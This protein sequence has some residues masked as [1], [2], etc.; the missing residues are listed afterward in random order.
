[1][2]LH[3]R[4]GKLLEGNN[5]LLQDTEQLKNE[6][7]QLLKGKQELIRGKNELLQDTEQLKNEN[8]QLLKKVADLEVTNEELLQKLKGQLRYHNYPDLS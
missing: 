3:G 8:A 1:M 4:V 6:N 5:E 7:A 2:F